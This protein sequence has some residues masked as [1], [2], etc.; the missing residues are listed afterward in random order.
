MIRYSNGELIQVGDIVRLGGGSLWWVTAAAR[1]NDR[2]VV[3]LERSG[4]YT[5]TSVWGDDIRRLK[6]HGL[7]SAGGDNK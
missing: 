6:R 4:G 7:A 1:I 5:T 3:S 2:E